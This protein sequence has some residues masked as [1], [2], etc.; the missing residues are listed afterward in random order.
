MH[1]W[2][3]VNPAPASEL[4]DEAAHPFCLRCAEWPNVAQPLGLLA[5]GELNGQT[6]PLILM[7]PSA[8]N[9]PLP[10]PLI[11]RR[12]S[13]DAT[14][15]RSKLAAWTVDSLVLT[16]PIRQLNEASFNA[17]YSA[18]DVE[19]GADFVFYHWFT[20]QLKRAFLRDQYLPSLYYDTQ[21]Q[22]AAQS[23]RR[24]RKR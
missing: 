3:E 2:A 5:K 9:R 21:R 7:L 14:Q 24:A 4:I 12:T 10:S 22:R 16:Q 8:R 18:G 17:S 6:S 13:S 15:V 1:L 11:A 23:S 20:Q 19:L